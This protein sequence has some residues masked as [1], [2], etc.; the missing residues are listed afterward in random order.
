MSVIDA[1]ATARFDAREL[2]TFTRAVIGAWGAPPEVAEETARHLVGANLA[3]HDSHGMVRMP[4]YEAQVAAGDIA[5]AALPAVLRS[6]STT[7]LIDAHRGFGMFSTMFA[8]EWAARAAAKHGIAAA[9]VRHSSHIGRLGEYSE[10]IAALGLVGIVTVGMAGPGVGGMALFGSRG[11]FFGAN[12]WSI[13]VPAGEQPPMMFDG[14]TSMVAEGKVRVARSKKARLPEGVIVDRDGNPTTDPEDFYAGGAL[15]PLGGAVVGHKGYGLALASALIGG[16]AMIDDPEP[17][18]A[19]SYVGE[20]DHG[21]QGRI[22]GVFLIAID[23]RAFGGVAPYRRLVDEVLGAAKAMPPA[24]GATILTPGE[25][26]VRTREQR[27]RQGIELP[28]PTIDDLTRI[29]TAHGLT[30]PARLDATPKATRRPHHK[31]GTR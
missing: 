28:Q 29:G 5:P 21:W 20:A 8:T 2:E 31:E 6:T 1:P 10:R 14:S 23:P 11:R 13:G 4:Q 27:L 16:L 7:A 24:P 18:L 12:P 25:L 26:E 17:T 22:A 19:G 9:A 30:L 15:L 3:G